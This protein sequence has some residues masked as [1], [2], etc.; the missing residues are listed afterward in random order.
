MKVVYLKN[1]FL[2]Y[3]KRLHLRSSKEIFNYMHLR[4]DIWVL[5]K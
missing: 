4:V 1:H 5:K 2:F 3:L